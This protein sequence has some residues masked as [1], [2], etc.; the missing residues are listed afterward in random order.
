MNSIY[1]FGGTDLLTQSDTL[2]FPIL[3]NQLAALYVLFNAFMFKRKLGQKQSIRQSI[4]SSGIKIIQS[5]IGLNRHRH[6]PT[7]NFNLF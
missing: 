6:L 2:K 4:R 7:L 5:I 3:L 1:S